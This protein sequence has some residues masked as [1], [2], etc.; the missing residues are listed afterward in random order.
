M[1]TLIQQHIVEQLQL[2]T[3]CSIAVQSIGGGSINNCYRLTAGKNSFFCKLNSASNFPQLF[4]KEKVGLDLL[5]QHIAV[6]GVIAVLHKGD[7][8]VLV[9]DW[10]EEGARDK[11]FWTSFGEKLAQLHTVQHATYG[12]DR[13]NYMGSLPQSNQLSADWNQFFIQHRLQPLVRACFDKQLLHQKH[14]IQFEKLY[15]SLSTVFGIQKP[16]LVHGDLWSGNFLA[17]KAGHVVLIDPAAY[18]GIPAVDIGMTLLF[19]GFDRVFYEV[20]FHHNARESNFERQCMVCNLYPL[21]VHLRLFG[22]SYLSSVEQI[23]REA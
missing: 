18:F 13:D 5:G 6:P 9:L 10:V 2:D 19:G 1:D 4:E 3:S 14:I 16:V 21:L 17:A 15:A 7:Q 20:Y 12:L 8:Q 22:S 23:L 11:K